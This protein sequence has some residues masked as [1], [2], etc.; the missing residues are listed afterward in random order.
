M[1]PV[2]TLSGAGQ[3]FFSSATSLCSIISAVMPS[4]TISMVKVGPS[5]SSIVPASFQAAA[6]LCQLVVNNVGSQR[7]SQTAGMS[8]DAAGQ[9]AEEYA[10]QPCRDR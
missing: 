6:E 9:W 5:R 4:S 10:H 7:Q 1:A 2:C 3:P 8:C